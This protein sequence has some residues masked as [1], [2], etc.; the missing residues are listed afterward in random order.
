MKIEKGLIVEAT[1]R[2]LFSYYLS[3]SFDDIMPFSTFMDLMKGRG[4]N[5]IEE[6]EEEN[7]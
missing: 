6:S 4:V 1:E 7:E 2:E 3:R 5:I